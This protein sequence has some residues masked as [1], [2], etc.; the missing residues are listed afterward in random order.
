MVCNTSCLQVVMK[1]VS[2]RGCLGGALMHWKDSFFYSSSLVHLNLHRTGFN[3]TVEQ[4]EIF[5]NSFA[6]DTSFKPLTI[7]QTDGFFVVV[8]VVYFKLKPVNLTC[9][10]TQ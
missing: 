7:K 4:K 8:V 2:V 9:Y 3:Q 10:A 5:R 6:Q 1:S